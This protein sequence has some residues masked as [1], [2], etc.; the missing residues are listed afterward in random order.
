MRAYQLLDSPM[1]LARGTYALNSDKM[2]TNPQKN[3][4]GICR[5]EKWDICGALQYCYKYSQATTILNEI[6]R[7]V[8]EIIDKNNEHPYRSY[9]ESNAHNTIHY[10]GGWVTFNDRA[11][12]SD[13]IAMLKQVEDSFHFFTK[14]NE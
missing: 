9:T 1:K 5:A 11:I 4:D 8:R 2:F 10:W 13:I 7:L 12:F 3:Q 14:E 6:D